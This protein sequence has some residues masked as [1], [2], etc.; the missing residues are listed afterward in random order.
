MSTTDSNELLKDLIEDD[1][2]KETSVRWSRRAQSIA[3]IVWSAFLAAAVATVLAFAFVDPPLIGLATSPPIEF[4]RM[5]GYAIGFFYLWT[6]SVI[7]ATLA[8]YLIRRRTRTG[9]K[10]QSKPKNRK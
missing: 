7:A 6:V 2:E 9:S 8:V 10:T 4:S 3:A 5:T 1:V